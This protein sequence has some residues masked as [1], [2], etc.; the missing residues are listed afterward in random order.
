M[1][2]NSDH[3]NK[4]CMKTKF[5]SDDN[6]PLNKTIENYNLTIVV[7]AFFY[8]NNKCYPQVSLDDCRYKRQNWR[9]NMN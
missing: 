3:Y 9:V 8:E 2:K 5:D 6:L 1:T 4:K 7:R